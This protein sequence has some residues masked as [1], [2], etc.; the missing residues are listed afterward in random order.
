M[1]TVRLLVLG[2]RYFWTPKKMKACSVIYMHSQKTFTV[3]QV[4]QRKVLSQSLQAFA[5]ISLS[6]SQSSH[7][8]SLTQHFQPKPAVFQL[9]RCPLD[10]STE[11]VKLRQV[12]CFA[13]YCIY[14][15][16]THMWDMSAFFNSNLYGIFLKFVNC[17]L[18]K[19]CYL[20]SA[21]NN[22]I[23]FALF[24]NF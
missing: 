6:T 8:V 21:H 7:W 16:A 18:N 14:K 11:Q 17:A 19:G 13:P 22:W 24:L 3:W 23:G 15:E 12:L 10:W 1:Y 9:Q 2:R 5:H 4:P 20:K